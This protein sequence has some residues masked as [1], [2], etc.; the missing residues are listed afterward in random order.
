MTK[1]SPPGQAMSNVLVQLRKLSP[2]RPLSYSESLTMAKLQAHTARKILGLTGPS[3]SLE[4]AL[5]LPR[6]EVQ[7]LPAFKMIELGEN[8]SGFTT[9]QTNG[10]YVI[11]I[12][13]SNSYTHRRWT[14]VHELKHLIDFPY[15]NVL[16]RKLGFG[17]KGLQARQIERV[18]DHFAAHFLVP[19]SL[20]KQAWTRGIRDVLALA[21]L[22]DVSGE[23]MQ[24]RLNNE[25][26]LDEERP[27]PDYFRQVY[28]P[29]VAVAA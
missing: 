22:F 5:S 28:V 11:G 9:R 20:L 3:A 6:V 14:L 7:L 19:T 8:T 25:G 29:E 4:W 18:C 13:R 26:F 17:D 10:T 24:I 12:N 2:K 27:L 16:H 1:T 15:A 21:A 23:A